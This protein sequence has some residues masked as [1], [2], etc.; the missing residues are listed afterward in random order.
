MTHDPLCHNPE[1][2]PPDTACGWCWI[3][4]KTRKDERNKLHEK[5]STMNCRVHDYEDG[6]C[7]VAIDDLI[8]ML[9][10]S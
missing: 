5:V 7:H 4:A 10:T 9:E 8:K 2:M 1:P 6:M 3:I